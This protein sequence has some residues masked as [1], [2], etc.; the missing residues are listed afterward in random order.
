MSD[1]CLSLFCVTCPGKCGA[2]D[3]CCGD[4]MTQLKYLL[5]QASAPKDTAAILVEP[6]LGEGGYVVPPPTFFKEL[7]EFCDKHGI[8]LIAD[9]VGAGCCV[10]DCCCGLFIGM[11]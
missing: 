8:L 4:P 3:G 1:V 11:D 7:R 6:I 9:E 5:K 10:D 2:G